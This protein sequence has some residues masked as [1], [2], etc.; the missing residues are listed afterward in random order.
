[1]ADD[2]TEVPSPPEC[3]VIP[4][5]AVA[6]AK[7]NLVGV[8]RLKAKELALR[9][10]AFQNVYPFRFAHEDYEDCQ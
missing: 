1:M 5:G 3:R 8:Q 4:Q 2:V 6:D 10:V 7:G 9:E